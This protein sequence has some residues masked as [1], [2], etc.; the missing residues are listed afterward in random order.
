M[1]HSLYCSNCYKAFLKCES[2]SLSN[3]SIF[4]RSVIFTTQPAVDTRCF[5][6]HLLYFQLSICKTTV[7]ITFRARQLCVRRVYKILWLCSFV[8]LNEIKGGRR[9]WAL[10]E[11]NV[12]VCSSKGISR[13]DCVFIRFHVIEKPREFNLRHFLPYYKMEK[14]FFEANKIGDNC[15]LKVLDFLSAL[16]RGITSFCS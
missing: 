15:I 2:C 5:S 6:F 13:R 3:L 1:L 4:S 16:I 10:R 12:Y 11:I 9:L 8:I 7:R 14:G